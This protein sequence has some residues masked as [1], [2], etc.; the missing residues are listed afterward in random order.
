MPRH[1]R[2][3]PGG[4]LYHALNRGVAR[5]PLFEKDGDYQAFEQVLAEALTACP[6]RVL[7]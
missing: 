2:V 7:S 3:A 4:L 5:L 6:T 1:P